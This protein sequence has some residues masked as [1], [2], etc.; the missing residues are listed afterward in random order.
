MVEAK[1]F[2]YFKRQCK[3]E[4]FV[5]QLGS[6]NEGG[7][8]GS[9]IGGEIMQEESEEAE[10]E[11]TEEKPE[12]EIIGF[13]TRFCYT[14]EGLMVYDIHANIKL[15]K[16]RAENNG[17]TLQDYKVFCHSLPNTYQHNDEEECYQKFKSYSNALAPFA[18]LEFATD[19][20]TLPS[21]I[22]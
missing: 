5:T 12:K 19:H 14:R 6:K 7:T 22:I 4:K 9:F 3:F 17:I 2:M 11:P 16:N 13:D 20:G 8:L 18:G 10:T 15:D 1:D 21:L